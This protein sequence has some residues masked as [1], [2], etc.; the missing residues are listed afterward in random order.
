[1]GPCVQ[2][3]STTLASLVLCGPP[4]DGIVT[5]VLKFH[6]SELDAKQ[7][8]DKVHLGEGLEAGEEVQEVQL[9]AASLTAK[10]NSSTCREGWTRQMA[11]LPQ[12][13]WV[14]VQGHC[15]PTPHT[16]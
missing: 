2:G 6:G 12:P 3:G 8:L 16:W 13:R 1:M 9:P 11:E 14:L 4:T 10:N 7:R 5:A 15:W